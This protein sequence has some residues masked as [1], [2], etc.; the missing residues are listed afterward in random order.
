MNSTNRNHRA[1]GPAGQVTTAED[2]D[3]DPDQN[4]DPDHPQ[5]DPKIVQN[6]FNNG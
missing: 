3:E 4:P 5:E 6:T 2:V 1:S